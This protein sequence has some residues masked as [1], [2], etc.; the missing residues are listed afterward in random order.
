MGRYRQRRARRER[1]RLMTVQIT[2][3]GTVTPLVDQLPLDDFNPVTLA[4][5]VQAANLAQRVDRKYLVGLETLSQLCHQLT[6]SHRVL[7]IN[8]RRTTT[9]K[10]TYFDTPDLRSCRAHVQGRRRRWKVRSRL[11]VEDQL[12]RVEVKTKSG[13]GLTDKVVNP[14]QADRYGTLTGPDLTFVAA[15]LSAPHPDVEVAT[16]SPHAEITYTRA[17]LVDLNGGTRIT[18][19]GNLTSVLAKG[20]VWIDADYVIVETKGGTMPAAADRILTHLGAR[21]RSFSKYVATTSLLHPDIADNDVRDLRRHCL[22]ST[23]RR[24]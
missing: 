17:C 14:S 13:R 9:Y 8:D 20:T 15:T 19:D 18:V 3:P 4:E 7:E 2:T 21:P 22:R 6:G 24:P 16:L 11:Y 10:T 12:C 1:C 23:T 5:T